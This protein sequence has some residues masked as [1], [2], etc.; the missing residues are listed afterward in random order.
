MRVVVFILLRN[1]DRLRA[2]LICSVASAKCASRCPRP[3]GAVGGLLMGEV[4]P[5]PKVP[6]EPS[7]VFRCSLPSASGLL[8]RRR[9][10]VNDCV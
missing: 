10:H 9:L 8:C 1:A 2:H 3:P 6:S 4:T 7:S 5:K